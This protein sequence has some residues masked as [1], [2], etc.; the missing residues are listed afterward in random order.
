MVVS[1]ICYFH[2]YFGKV[3]ILTII[4]F[5]WVGSTTKQKVFGNPW[6]HLSLSQDA[7][8]K[9]VKLL[10]ALQRA[11]GEAWRELQFIPML[12]QSLWVFLGLL[13][14]SS[15]LVS[16]YL[17]TKDSKS[18]KDRVVGPLPNGLFMAY[19]LGLLTTC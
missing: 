13:G 2:P 19:T 17:A 12:P 16:I 8:F 3:P 6:I 5:R 7:D 10:R 4:F 15:H 11:E 14:G 1:N 9:A 18:C